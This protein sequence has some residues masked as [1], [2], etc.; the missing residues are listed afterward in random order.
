MTG[1]K[2]FIWMSNSWSPCSSPS[3][4]IFNCTITLQLLALSMFTQSDHNMI[5]TYKGRPTHD[6]HLHTIKS[7]TY[8]S[9]KSRCPHIDNTLSCHYVNTL[10]GSTTARLCSRAY[11]TKASHSRESQTCANMADPPPPGKRINNRRK[12]CP[13]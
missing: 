1:T 3:R 13:S 10:D 11:R 2:A 6:L 4:S 7:N 5:Y 9:W 12:I 8:V